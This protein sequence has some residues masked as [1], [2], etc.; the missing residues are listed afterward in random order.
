MQT[1]GRL[2]FQRRDNKNLAGKMVTHFLG[3]IRSTY[4]LSTSELTEE[5]EKK[6][7][8]KSGYSAETVK[9][10]IQDIKS[11]EAKTSVSDEELLAFNDKLEQFYKQT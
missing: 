9:N 3:Y 10:I 6:L 2:Y 11:I 7:A 8:F 5:F 4:N 1:V